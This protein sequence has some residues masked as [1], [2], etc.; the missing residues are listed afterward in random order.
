MKNIIFLFLAAVMLSAGC[1]KDKA[2]SNYFVTFMVN[3]VKKSFTN[4]TFGHFEATGGFT[5]LSML[6]ANSPTADDNY[7]GIYINNYPGLL[8]ISTGVYNDS[9]TDFTVL[10]TYSIDDVEYEGG[11]TMSDNVI[12]YNIPNHQRFT[13]TIT[14]ITTTNIRGTF[15]GDYYES[16]DV[17]YGAKLAITNGEFNVQVR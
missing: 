4:Y 1:S 6:G 12:Q 15:S 16:G 10:A 8:P 13:V 5:E 11:Q 2:E 17:Q 7:C 14:E 9:S 3:G